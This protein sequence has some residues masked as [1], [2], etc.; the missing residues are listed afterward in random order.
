MNKLPQNFKGILWSRK[1]KKLDLNKDKNY[2]I[3]QVLAYGNWN[4]IKWLFNTYSKG[5]VS[6]IFV[7]TPQK[8]YSPSA[9]N[10][11]KN[12]LLGLKKVKIDSK[13][14]VKTIF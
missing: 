2:I 1:I 14:Y 9:F 13:A 12:H 8:K 5:K 6:Q 3:H 4:Q 11:V 10:F 7:N